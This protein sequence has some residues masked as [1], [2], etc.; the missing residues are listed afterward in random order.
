MKNK[1]ILLVVPVYNEE[2][3]VEDSI[4]KLYDYMTFN[5]KEDWSV[6]IADNASTDQTKDISKKL[7]QKYKKIKYIHL[8]Y[9][10]R[11]NALKYVW[12]HFNADVYAYCDVDLSTDINCLTVLFNEILKGHDIV[13]G[14]RYLK[15]SKTKRTFK[16]MV[17]SKGY[18]HLI[19]IFFKTKLTDFQC[20]FKAID[21]K[22]AHEV[23]PITEN[24][25]WFF[26]TELLLLSEQSKKYKIKE[27][28]VKW[29]EGKDSKVKIFNTIY[30]YIDQILKLR[31]RLNEKKI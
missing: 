20:G 26:D 15:D 27:I 17:L 24:K 6:V 9:K 12:G 13:S 31:L 3:I 23:L 16:R 14:S 1:K 5:I 19:K 7:S 29:K 11:G 28:P 8:G 25:E 21:K 18:N 30:S 4:K 10:G 2:K 22:I